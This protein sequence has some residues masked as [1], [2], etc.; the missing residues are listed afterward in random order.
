MTQYEKRSGSR[1]VRKPIPAL[2]TLKGC[3][4]PL[5]VGDGGEGTCIKSQRNARRSLVAQ[6]VKNLPA[7]Q[8]TWI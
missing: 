6:T 7:V 8:E 3:T 4:C 1:S 2:A 5:E